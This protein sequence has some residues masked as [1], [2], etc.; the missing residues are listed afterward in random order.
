M[1]FTLIQER[2]NVPKCLA[3]VFV[4]LDGFS[5]RRERRPDLSDLNLVTTRYVRVMNS[6]PEDPTNEGPEIDA[7][8]ANVPEPTT[9]LLMAV[10]LV[11]ASFR[12]RRW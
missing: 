10:G 3:N 5:F 9:M 1:C 4:D 12:R 11:A 2:S 8:S 6:T 7:I